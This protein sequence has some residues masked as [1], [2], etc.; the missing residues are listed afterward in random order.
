[1]SE[2]HPSKPPL[3]PL[4]ARSE[5]LNSRPA[6]AFHRQ[7]RD[8]LGDPEDHLP[9]PALRAAEAYSEQR[10]LPWLHDQPQAVIRPGVI[11]AD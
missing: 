8:P 2:G 10:Q 7:D 11:V 5:K 1:M 3:T 4:N 9:Q 6:R